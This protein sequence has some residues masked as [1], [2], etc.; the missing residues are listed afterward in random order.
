MQLNIPRDGYAKDNF[1]S[2]YSLLRPTI[3]SHDM[4]NIEQHYR[5]S[6]AEI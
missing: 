2:S 5:Q 6:N 4:P 3:L 1:E